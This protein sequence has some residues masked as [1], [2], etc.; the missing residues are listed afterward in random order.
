VKRRSIAYKPL[1]QNSNAATASSLGFATT[2]ESRTTTST[3]YSDI[4]DKD[5]F[6]GLQI[7]LAAACNKDLG[8]W[9]MKMSGCR[10]RRFLADL[11][12]LEGLGVNTL[13]NQGKETAMKRRKERDQ[14]TR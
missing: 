13:A 14:R 11:R 8:L 3:G 2:S 4:C 9:I 5:V 7:A 10:V 6:K 1:S 12:A